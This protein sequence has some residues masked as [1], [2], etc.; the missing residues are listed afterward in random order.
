MD[1][2]EASSTHYS[3]YSLGRS[4]S[5]SVGPPLWNSFSFPAQGRHG[6]SALN[7]PTV[8]KPFDKSVSKVDEIPDAARE[9]GRSA[10][11][12]T[13]PAVSFAQAAASTISGFTPSSSR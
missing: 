11:S 8:R 13:H 10:S 6:D 3:V 12:T 4:V 1:C 2:L 5:R 7:C 9:N